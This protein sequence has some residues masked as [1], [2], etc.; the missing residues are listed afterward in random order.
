M[1]SSACIGTATHP[2]RASLVATNTTRL[3]RRHFNS[4]PRAVTRAIKLPQ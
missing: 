1:I 3:Q 2:R 4:M